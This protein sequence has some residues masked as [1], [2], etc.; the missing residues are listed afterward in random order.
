MR[1]SGLPWIRSRTCRCSN[2]CMNPGIPRGRCGRR[3]TVG[4]TRSPQP[5]HLP[6]RMIKVSFEAADPSGLHLVVVGAHADDIEIGCGGTLLRLAGQGRI[7]SV[8][9]LVFSA[10]GE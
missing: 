3:A 5:S 10:L 4:E 6:A 1:A 7:R 9:W 2:R 8:D